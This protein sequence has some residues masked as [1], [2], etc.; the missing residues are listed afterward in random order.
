M[1]DLTV[2]YSNS[3]S[4]CNRPPVWDVKT[5]L[6]VNSFDLKLLCCPKLEINGTLISQINGSCIS[7]QGLDPLLSEVIPNQGYSQGTYSIVE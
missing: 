7:N 6:P 1:G 4:G 5:L 2:K 3:T